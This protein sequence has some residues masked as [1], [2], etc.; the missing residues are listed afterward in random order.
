MTAEIIDGKAVAAQV[1]AEVAADVKAL[2]ARG[3][4]PGLAVV[5]VRLAAV[6]HG[7]IECWHV[8]FPGGMLP[9]FASRGRR[10]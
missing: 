3:V 7:A 5:L 2:A 6:D 9:P 8:R 1:R 10:V 4:T